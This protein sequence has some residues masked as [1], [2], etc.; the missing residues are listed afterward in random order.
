M[1]LV[2]GTPA[3]TVYDKYVRAVAICSDVVPLI[4]PALGEAIDRRTLLESIDGLMLT[5][6]PSNVFPEHYGEPPTPESEPHDLERDDT[7]LPLIREAVEAS[8]PLFAIC[9]GLQEVN[10]AFGGTL[11]VR[12]H[13]IPGRIDHR[14]PEH[15]DPDIQHGPRHA[16]R[17]T[18]DGLLRKIVG[19]DELEVNSLHWQAIDKLAPALAVEAVASDGTIEGARV[20]NARSFAVGVQWHPEYKA[21]ESAP[22]RRLFEAFGDAARKRAA[23]RS[24]RPTAKSSARARA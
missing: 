16:V 1:R 5:G 10:V 17:L 13:E 4:I 19:A 21:W 11:N 24:G 6:S 8:V 12:V 3:H 22:S 14:R 18:P 23:V 20:D 2:E 9:R 7:T 15:P